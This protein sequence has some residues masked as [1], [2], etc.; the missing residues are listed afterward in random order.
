MD[1]IL[2]FLDANAVLPRYRLV[3]IA[4]LVAGLGPSLAGR[5]LGGPDWVGLLGLP[6]DV[7]LVVLTYKRLRDAAL[8]GAWIWLM[9]FT[10][11]IGPSWQGFHLGNLINFIPMV[12]GWIVPANSGAYPRERLTA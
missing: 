5:L 7:L 6:F 4:L 10:F 3:S 11:N 9:V 8:A 2:D 12:M 1:A